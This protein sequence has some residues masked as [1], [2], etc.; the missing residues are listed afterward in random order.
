ML[1][2]SICAMQAKIKA[3]FSETRVEDRRQLTQSESKS[4]RRQ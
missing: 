2:S 3:F 4:Q 1:L